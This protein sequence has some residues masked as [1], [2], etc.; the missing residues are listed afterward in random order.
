MDVDGDGNVDTI[1]LNPRARPCPTLSVSFHDGPSVSLELRQ[2]GIDTDFPEEGFPPRVLRVIDLGAGTGSG[3]IVQTFTG[4]TGDAVAVILASRRGLTRLATPIELGSGNSFELSASGWGGASIG[5]TET[6]EIAYVVSGDFT[7]GLDNHAAITTLRV[8][9]ARAVVAGR[10]V[11][12]L[13]STG[14]RRIIRG[15]PFASCPRP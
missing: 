1:L 7:T 15:G 13:R 3:I 8:R 6:G 9:A 11:V 4:G 14:W 5:C 10:T 12:S 2:F